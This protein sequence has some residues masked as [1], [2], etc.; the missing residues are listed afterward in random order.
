MR[1]T[2]FVSYSGPYSLGDRLPPD[3]QGREWIVIADEE[4]NGVER[5]VLRAG[6]AG[7]LVV[8]WDE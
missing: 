2:R 4:T 1:E 8:A 5:L 7:E 6:A 3:E